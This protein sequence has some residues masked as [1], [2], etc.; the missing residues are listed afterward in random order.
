MDLVVDQLLDR[1]RIQARKKVRNYPMLMGQGVWLGSEKLGPDDE[2]GEVLK[3]GTLTMGF[4]GLAECLK[5][6]TGFHHGAVG[7]VAE[8]GASD[9]FA[10]AGENRPCNRRNRTEFQ[11][12]LRRPAEG[13]FRDVCPQGQGPLWV[14]SGIY[15]P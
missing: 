13:T 2:V 11:P 15:R 8:T 6:L 14:S 9:Y 7:R 3:Q 1:F 4:I 10:Y 5:A 12:D